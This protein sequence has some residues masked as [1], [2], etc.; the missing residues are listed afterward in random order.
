MKYWK[1]NF[2][3]FFNIPPIRYN[4]LESPMYQD[5]ACMERLRHSSVA[6]DSSKKTSESL[7]FR[8]IFSSLVCKFIT[9]RSGRSQKQFRQELTIPEVYRGTTTWA[10]EQGRFPHCTLQTY[11]Q[12]DL[13][14]DRTQAQMKAVVPMLVMV[15]SVFILCWTPILIFEVSH[16][17]QCNLWVS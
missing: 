4:K 13:R 2:S 8:N 7:R 3:I 5:S 17:A 12:S 10:P 9:W 14:E 15:V 1:L 16:S 11:L 6:G